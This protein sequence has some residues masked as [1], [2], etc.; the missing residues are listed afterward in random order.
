MIQTLHDDCLKIINELI[1]N[2]LSKIFLDPIDPNDESYSEYLSI[3]KKPQFL[4]PIKKKLEEN[5]Y[6]NYAEFEKDVNLVFDNTKK[7][8]GP[9]SFQGIIASE[10]LRK[11]QKLSKR[12]LATTSTDYWLQTIKI[13]YNKMSDEL[14]KAPPP[15]KGKFNIQKDSEHVPRK[16]LSKLVKA[17]DQLKNRDDILG[18]AQILNSGGLNIDSNKDKVYVNLKTVP[19]NTAMALVGFAKERFNELNLKYPS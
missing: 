2:R 17:S 1:N 9:K 5:Q 12:A 18:I 19:Y 7:F 3:I 15:L 8:F 4:R 11:F 13:L 14:A 10:M 6:K 16:E